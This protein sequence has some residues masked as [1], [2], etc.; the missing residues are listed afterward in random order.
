MSSN[1]ETVERRCS[2]CGKSQR[3]VRKIISG[4]GVC[5][6]DACV[7]VRN[8]VLAEEEGGA[9]AGPRAQPRVTPV[10]A[11]RRPR[12]GMAF[13]LQCQTEGEA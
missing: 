7:G 5:I 6:C 8:E 11:F 3:Q 2:F 4:P 13:A 12:C 9:P 1:A 10:G